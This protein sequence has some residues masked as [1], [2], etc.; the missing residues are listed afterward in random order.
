MGVAAVEVLTVTVEGLF[1][2]RELVEGRGVDAADAEDITSLH[3]WASAGAAIE[4]SR[5]PKHKLHRI[6]LVKGGVGVERG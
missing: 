1:G 6:Q 2:L 3:C 4:P 5:R